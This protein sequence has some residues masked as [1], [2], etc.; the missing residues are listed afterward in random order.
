[1][2]Q[3]MLG[4]RRMTSPKSGE[5]LSAAMQLFSA[6]GYSA[7]SMRDIAE[8]VGLQ[9]GSLYAHIR[10]K[11]D[12]LVEIIEGVREAFLQN[13]ETALADTSTSV[14]DRLRRFVTA[15]LQIIADNRESAVV[16]LH[17]WK[18]LEGA[19]LDDV[20]RNR[21]RYE[22]MLVALLEEGIESGELRD[23]DPHITAVAILSMLNWAYTWY[24]PDGPMSAADLGDHFTDLLIGGVGAGARRPR[25]RVSRR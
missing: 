13:G 2:S 12:L 3:E 11:E 20:R 17:E 25:R 10:S 5:I 8:A 6:K 1:M 18:S 15:H 23:V 7:T 21:D 4:G 14:P 16:F 22:S 19:Q 24:R 9:P